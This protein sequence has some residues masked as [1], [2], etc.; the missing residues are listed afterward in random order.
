[1]GRGEAPGAS[2]DLSCDQPFFCQYQRK[3]G[4]HAYILEF[5]V[6][7]PKK[8]KNLE[9]IVQNALRQIEEKKYAAELEAGGI[10]PEKI[11]KY[12]FAFEGKEVLIGQADGSVRN[13]RLCF[14][15]MIY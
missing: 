12:G 9:E 10:P 13:D 2:G 11:R 6:R 15:V 8:E 4:D 5:K 14:P 3:K 1:M 7:N